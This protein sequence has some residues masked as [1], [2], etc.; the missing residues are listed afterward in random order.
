MGQW[1]KRAGLQLT[2]PTPEITSLAPAKGKTTRQMRLA[3][4]S[5]P[6]SLPR[7]AQKSHPWEGTQIVVSGCPVSM[8]LCRGSLVQMS[9]MVAMKCLWRSHAAWKDGERGDGEGEA[10]GRNKDSPGRRVRGLAWDL[11]SAA[12][13]GILDSYLPS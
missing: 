9:T 12:P 11:G 7:L 8:L 4:P 6:H 2:P 5:M 1:E 3:P 10:N 13:C